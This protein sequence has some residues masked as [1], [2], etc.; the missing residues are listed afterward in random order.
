V[1]RSS[2]QTP[3]T[4]HR[5]ADGVARLFPSSVL[6]NSR[7]EVSAN[8][9]VHLL[10]IQLPTPGLPG[11]FPAVDY[12]SAVVVAPL[13]ILAVRVRGGL[14][15]CAV[16]RR[17]LATVQI[18]RSVRVQPG[19]GKHRPVDPHED[20]ECEDPRRRGPVDGGEI[21]RTNQRSDDAQENGE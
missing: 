6:L 1:Q 15:V 3:G 14:L 17:P 8:H 21:I 9:D 11:V 16:S 2:I 4:R 5:T 19:L 20:G 10:L 13:G 18:F 12:S 7:S